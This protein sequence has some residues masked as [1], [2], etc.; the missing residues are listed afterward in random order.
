MHVLCFLR[1][2]FDTSFPVDQYIPHGLVVVH[3]IVES[4]EAITNCLYLTYK[5]IKHQHIIF[6]LNNANVL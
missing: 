4:G 6:V 3:V 5:T 1:Y 2:G